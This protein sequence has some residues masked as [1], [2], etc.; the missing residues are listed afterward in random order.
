MFYQY[1]TSLGYDYLAL[2]ITWQ[3]GFCAVSACNFKATPIFSLHGLWP[4]NLLKA[5]PRNCQPTPAVTFPKD[6]MEIKKKWKSGIVSQ[7]QSITIPSKSQ[8]NIWSYEWK[9]HGTCMVGKSFTNNTLDAT[10]PEAYYSDTVYAFSNNVAGLS[11]K[12]FD[13][14][15]KPGFEY[16]ANELLSALKDV[17]GSPVTIVCA[18]A[19]DKK[20][21]LQESAMFHDK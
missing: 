16:L 9:T 12:L 1:S 4:S 6:I 13:K 3:K 21:Y 18:T 2:S 15:V 14:N 19:N 17:I 8:Y 5:S 10:N 20:Q 11:R 7:L